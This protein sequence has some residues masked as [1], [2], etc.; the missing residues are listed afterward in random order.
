ME[1]DPR[2]AAVVMPTAFALFSIAIAVA[3]V[4]IIRGP[5]ILDRMIATDVLLSTLMCSFAVFIVF[6]GRTDLQFV[7]LAMA[8]FGFVGSVAVSRYV[9]RSEGTVHA[10][11]A[12]DSTSADDSSQSTQA[13]QSGAQSAPADGQREEEGRQ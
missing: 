12:D 10:P 5:A 2:V 11:P 3:I 13:S 6:T 1:F 9:A 7:L 4:R 8:F